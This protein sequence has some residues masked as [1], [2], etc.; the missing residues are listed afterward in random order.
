MAKKS[1]L[2][3]LF[4]YT[5]DD[6]KKETPTSE[7][8]ETKPEV[9]SSL[10]SPITPSV[11]TSQIITKAS[12]TGKFDS[13]L[14]SIIEKENLPGP[15]VYELITSV[16]EL[17]SAGLSEDQAYRSAFTA[18]KSMGLTK[19]RL[20]E[21]SNHY[22]NVVNGVHEEF[23]TKVIG[24]KET[25]HSQLDQQR[26]DKINEINRLTE[27][28]KGLNIQCNDLQNEISENKQ[29]IEGSYNKVTSFFNDVMN[30]I[31]NYLT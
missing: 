14:E 7:N 5:S 10:L 31:Q 18:F 16:K 19:E 13:V 15:D 23:K 6:K 28:V 29:E 26:S 21:T 4:E 27:E 8:K 20:L 1:F 30:K 2:G 12:Y 22:I 17:M 24:Q 25:E 9:K 11:Q 3:S